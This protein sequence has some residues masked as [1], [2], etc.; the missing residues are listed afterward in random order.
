MTKKFVYQQVNF[1]RR[2]L[3]EAVEF[4]KERNIPLEEIDIISFQEYDW[5]SSYTVS[6]LEYKRLE[7]DSEY[8]K[9]LKSEKE[10]AE[11]RE[12]KERLLYQKLSEK[13]FNN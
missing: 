9:R 2:S 4:A 5:D 1:S 3:A 12:R 7:S 10:Q 11:E 13:Y 8:N 6:G